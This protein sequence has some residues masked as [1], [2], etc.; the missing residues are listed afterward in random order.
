MNPPHPHGTADRFPFRAD[1]RKEPEHHRHGDR[2]GPRHV[3]TFHGGDELADGGSGNQIFSHHNRHHEAGQDAAAQKGKIVQRPRQ[4]RHDGQKAVA[5]PQH[6]NPS[7][8]ALPLPLCEEQRK[9][10][11]GEDR[12]DRPQ[13]LPAQTSHH[14]HGQYQH[15]RQLGTGIQEPPAG[16]LG[17]LRRVGHQAS[18]AFSK[19][20][21][22]RARPSSPPRSPHTKQAMSSTGAIHRGISFCTASI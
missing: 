3:Q 20:F 15:Q 21:L 4:E 9:R 13:R 19:C 22:S 1:G 16:F 5:G 2:N 12:L 17:T 10:Q 14:E 6:D 18:P 8:E 11:S 7:R